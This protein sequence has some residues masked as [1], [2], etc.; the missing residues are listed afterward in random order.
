MLSTK[1]QD[2][3]FPSYLYTGLK[4]AAVLGT[5][6]FLYLAS[7]MGLQACTGHKQFTWLLLFIAK[8]RLLVGYVVCTLLY[9]HRYVHII[10][11]ISV[12]HKVQ[13][14]YRAKQKLRFQF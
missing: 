12:D 11:K 10:S 14:M 9:N 6:N 4:L 8:K 13:N 7:Y 1:S 3:F 2:R 5:Y